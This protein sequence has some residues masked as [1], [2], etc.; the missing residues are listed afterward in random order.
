MPRDIPVGNGALLITFDRYYQMRDFY[1]PHPGREN[2]SSGRPFRFGVWA[3][4]QFSWV[5]SDDWSRNLTYQDDTLV[6]EVRLRC[7][8]LGLELTVNDSVDFY[9]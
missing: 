1:F 6:T 8:R 7:D 2:Q 4:G 5:A 9:E 3:D